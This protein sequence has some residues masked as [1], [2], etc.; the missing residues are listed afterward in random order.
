MSKE[1]DIKLS[2]L[3]KTLIDLKN[4]A[5]NEGSKIDNGE[6]EEMMK[7]AIESMTKGKTP[8]DSR[9]EI[10]MQKGMQE[11]RVLNKRVR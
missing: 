9:M 7:E 6:A 3:Q 8:N 5:V 10:A 4:L 2:K 11:L 1:K